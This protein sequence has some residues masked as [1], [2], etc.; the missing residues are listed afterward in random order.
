MKSHSSSSLCVSLVLLVCVLI[1]QQANQSAGID[2]G[3]K[4]DKE[5]A[6]Y[7]DTRGFPIQYI[8]IQG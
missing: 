1:L 7:F 5:C 2:A 4:V 3:I 8:I 6:T